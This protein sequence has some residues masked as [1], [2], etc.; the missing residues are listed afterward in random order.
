MIVSFAYCII[1]KSSLIG[2]ED[3]NKPF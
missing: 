2:I 1:V 3:V